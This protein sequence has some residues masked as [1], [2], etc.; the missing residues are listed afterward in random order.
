MLYVEYHVE[1]FSTD[2]QLLESW[3]K[4]SRSFLLNFIKILYRSMSQDDSDVAN[5]ITAFD[6]TSNP[7]SVS[8]Y[9]SLFYCVGGGGKSRQRVLTLW[10]GYIYGENLGIVVGTDST[11]VAP[12]QTKLL[13]PIEHGTEADELE[14]F[15]MLVMDEGDFNVDAGADEAYFEIERIFRNASGGSITIR[16]IGINTLAYMSQV[17]VNEV[18]CILRDVDT[19]VVADGEYLKI[20][21]RIKVAS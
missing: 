17:I 8:F 19:I 5:M 9:R 10:D 14:Y 11:A 13:V 6:A 7:G 4:P 18:F 1:K 12:D 20:K 3:K 16:E 15:G 21:Y 2:G